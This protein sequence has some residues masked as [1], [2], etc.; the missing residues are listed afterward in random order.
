M[1]RALSEMLEWLSGAQPFCW[2]IHF[3]S[4][5]MALERCLWSHEPGDY[6]FVMNAAVLTAEGLRTQQSNAHT[7]GSSKDEMV[8]CHPRIR[9]DPTCQTIHNWQNMGSLAQ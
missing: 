4:Q 5:I 6:G 7:G 2:H 1:L 9:Q 8:H 3:P